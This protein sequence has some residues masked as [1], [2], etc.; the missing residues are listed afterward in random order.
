MDFK[1]RALSKKP[2]DLYPEALFVYIK[3]S[4][5]RITLNQKLIS[6]Y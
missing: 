3:R 4:F 5:L 2:Q 6:F 1:L